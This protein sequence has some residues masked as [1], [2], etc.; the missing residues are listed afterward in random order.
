[1]P[2][3]RFL[4]LRPTAQSLK[5]GGRFI[6]L[7]HV[8]GFLDI[9]KSYLSRVLNGK[10]NYTISYALTICEAL[11]MDIKEFKEAVD[12]RRALPKRIPVHKPRRKKTA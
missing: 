10:V 3:R 8:A 4:E 5:F 2:P 9:D 7:T 6:N 12:E 11:L 1:M